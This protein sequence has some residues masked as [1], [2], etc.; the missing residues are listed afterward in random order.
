M[1]PYLGSYGFEQAYTPN[2]DWLAKRSIQYSHAY[3]NSPVCAV[4][5]ATI[6]SGMYASTTGTY[7]MRTRVQL[8]EQIPA[9][10]K[11]MRET[12]YYCTSA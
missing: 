8:P 4:A 3:A 6:L 1:S 9:Y 2:L 5:R 7:Q 10:P 12:G 11:I